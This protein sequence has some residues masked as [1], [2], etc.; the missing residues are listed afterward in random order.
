MTVRSP[1][2]FIFENYCK[3]IAFTKE[4]SYYSLKKEQ[5]RYLILFPTNFMKKILDPRNAKEHY[6]LFLKNKAK[7]ITKTS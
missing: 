2:G 1:K 5:K 7:T 4:D 3:Q 6:Q